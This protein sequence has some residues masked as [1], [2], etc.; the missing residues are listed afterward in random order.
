MIW[1][2]STYSTATKIFFI[3]LSFLSPVIAF[4]NIFYSVILSKNNIFMFPKIFLKY[5]EFTKLW[6][7]AQKYSYDQIEILAVVLG[8]GLWE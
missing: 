5:K 8:R 2:I 1:Y 6:N 4:V 3:E 7:A